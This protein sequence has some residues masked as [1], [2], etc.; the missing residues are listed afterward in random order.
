MYTLFNLLLLKSNE[1]K[2]EKEI[3]ANMNKYGK[4]IYN[5]K[6]NPVT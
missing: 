3:V 6:L 2:K 1:I 5:A 4:R